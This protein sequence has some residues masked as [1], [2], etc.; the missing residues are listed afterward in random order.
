MIMKSIHTDD[1]EMVDPSEWLTTGQAA[2]LL[3]LAPGT[4]QNWRSQGRGPSFIK[5]GNSVFYTRKALQEYL[6]K[7]SSSYNSTTEWKEDNLG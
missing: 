1:F 6:Q 7:Y 4:L 2:G 3:K 5:R